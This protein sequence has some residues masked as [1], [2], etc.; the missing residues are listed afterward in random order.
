MDFMDFMMMIKNG[1][2]QWDE[3]GGLIWF[4]GI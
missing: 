4:N 1:N 2:F 3:N